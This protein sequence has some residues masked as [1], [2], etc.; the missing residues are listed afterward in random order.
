M[1]TL[2]ERMRLRA[3]IREVEETLEDV[4]ACL[5]PNNNI[6]SVEVHRRSIAC[7]NAVAELKRYMEEDLS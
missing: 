5:D 7:R 4:R 2:G 6:A 1:L 3:K